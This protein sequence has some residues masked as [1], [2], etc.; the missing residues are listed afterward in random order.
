MHAI[1]LIT[2]DASLL[3]QHTRN[4]YFDCSRYRKKG[5]NILKLLGINTGVQCMP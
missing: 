4:T 5:I 1:M 2:V 3:M